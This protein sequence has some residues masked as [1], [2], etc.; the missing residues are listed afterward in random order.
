MDALRRPQ[1]QAFLLFWSAVVAT[2]YLVTRS[3]QFAGHADLL[4]AAVT[5]DMVVLVPVAYLLLARRMGWRLISVVPV[6]V[7]TLAIAHAVI[8]KAHQ[9]WLNGAELLLAPLELILIGILILKVRAVRL[10]LR[11]EAPSADGFLEKLEQVL[12]RTVHPGRPSRIIATEVAMIAYGLFGWRWE[13]EQQPGHT[14][15]TYHK[16]CGHGT[17]IGVF[18]FLILVET[19]V[20][21]WYL[22]P[23]VPALSWCLLA[24][25]LYSEIFLLADLNAARLRPI[26]LDDGVLR[27]RTA[28]RWRAA[29]PLERIESVERTTIDIEDRTGL[30][31]AVLVGNQNVVLHLDGPVIASGLY[32]FTK[33]A[34]RISLA[35]D[36]PDGLVTAIAP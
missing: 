24:L 11:H 36:D 30:L 15:F 2:G 31:S 20:L 1:I 12:A 27:I 6:V 14:A 23:R 33:E 3:S 13:R 5:L 35:V 16:N 18:L 22:L 17:V 26:I 28:L 7:V 19:A 32:G 25:G 21:H 8:P 34:E 4:S 29:V 10:G 9:H